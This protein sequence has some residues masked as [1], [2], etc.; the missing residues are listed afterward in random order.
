VDIRLD[1]RIHKMSVRKLVLQHLLG[2]STHKIDRQSL[3]KVIT[4][5]VG[6][7]LF[8]IA[9][10]FFVDTQ[11]LGISVAQFLGSGAFGTTWA[12]I[13]KVVMTGIVLKIVR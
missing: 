8:G 5:T 10:W 11:I 12:F 2:N 9:F 3:K 6:W 4:F 1:K 13:D 7:Q